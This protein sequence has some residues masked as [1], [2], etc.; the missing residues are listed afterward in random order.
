M[1]G[2]KRS[3]PM[4]TPKLYLSMLFLCFAIYMEPVMAFFSKNNLTADEFVSYIK[5]E[6]QGG[7]VVKLTNFEIKGFVF[8]FK[9]IKS[10][11]FK[12]VLWQDIDSSG[13]IFEKILFEDCELRNINLEGVIIREVTFRNCTLHNVVMNKAKI[14]KLVFE[15][16]KLIST[17]SNIMHSYRNMV[18]DTIIFTDTELNN[19]NFF[20]S[21]GKF[22]F[23][24]AKLNDVSGMGLM[25]GSALYFHN[26]NAFDIDFSD[27]KLTTLEVK[28]STIKE[29]KANNCTIGKVVLEGGDLKFPI[30]EGHRYDTV[31]AK[32]TSNVVIGGTPI[33]EAIIT[34]CGRSDNI[35]VAGMTFDKMVINDCSPTNF[36]F[37]DSKGKFVSISN[38]DAV[39]FDLEDMDV[40]HLILENI[41][42]S[43]RLYYGNAKI[44]KLETKNISFDSDIKIKSDGANF[45]IKPDVINSVE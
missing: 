11:H 17:D 2:I 20:D 10:A 36:S 42:I 40:D 27:S 18:A 45:E 39:E 4:N 3:F 44:K 23:V 14:S 16:S 34:G 13:K 30:A 26:T 7:G 43:A 28:H 33:N 12:N 22:Y 15:K 25:E 19:I 41:H 8:P 21:K 6:Q 29:S 32:G 35:D 31:F 37:H 1:T 5:K 38:M 9:E 24:G